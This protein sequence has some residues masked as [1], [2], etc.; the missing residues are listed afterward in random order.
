VDAD[1]LAAD[2][3]GIEARIDCGRVVPYMGLG[4]LAD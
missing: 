2:D 4:R 1:D 3:L